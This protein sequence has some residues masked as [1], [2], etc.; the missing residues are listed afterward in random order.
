MC[1]RLPAIRIIIEALDF[2]TSEL[3]EA[4]MDGGI[5]T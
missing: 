4:L 2:E 5:D 1:R 3:N